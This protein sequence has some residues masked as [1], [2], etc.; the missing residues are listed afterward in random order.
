MSNNNYY[1]NVLVNVARTWSKSHLDDYIKGLEIQVSSI[2]ELLSEL[3]A[4]QKVEQ[5]KIDKKLRESGTR[6]AT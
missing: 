1:K 5:K 4:L 6:G 3:K 2:K